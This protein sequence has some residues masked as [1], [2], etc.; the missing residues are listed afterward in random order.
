MQLN[1]DRVDGGSDGKRL[2]EFSKDELMKRFQVAILKVDFNDGWNE[3]KI[4][5]KLILTYLKN[6]KIIFY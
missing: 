1:H 5:R 2:I 4:G 3:R 6:S